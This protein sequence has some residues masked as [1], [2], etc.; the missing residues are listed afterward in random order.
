[1]EQ[2]KKRKQGNKGE[3]KKGEI[4]NIRNK[5]NKCSSLNR[6]DKKQERKQ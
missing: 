4:E 1:M 6:K 3:I 5:E 2:K